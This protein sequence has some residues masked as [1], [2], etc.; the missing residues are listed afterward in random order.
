[1]LL[2]PQDHKHPGST[3]S[4][5]TLLV[6]EFFLDITR[7]KSIKFTTTF[8]LSSFISKI[9]GDILESKLVKNVPD[10]VRRP[11]EVIFY[12]PEAAFGNF[13][14]PGVLSPLLMSHPA[15]LE[16]NLGQKSNL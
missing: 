3:S 1:M 9:Y 7:K 16:P 13:Y 2:A 6:L 5:K 4:S 8:I 11:V 10:P 15:D 12:W 14:W